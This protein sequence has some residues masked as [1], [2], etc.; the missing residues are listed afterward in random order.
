MGLRRRA[1]AHYTRFWYRWIVPFL[2]DMSP[3]S[4]TRPTHISGTRSCFQKR[5]CKIFLCF[6]LHFWQPKGSEV[7][8]L[9]VSRA[10]YSVLKMARSSNHEEARHSRPCPRL[11][12]IP[13]IRTFGLMAPTLQDQSLY[14]EGYRYQASPDHTLQYEC[15]I[16]YGSHKPHA[17]FIKVSRTSKCSQDKVPNRLYATRTAPGHGLLVFQITPLTNGPAPDPNA[18]WRVASKLILGT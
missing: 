13:H 8:K 15:R 4:T 9:E 1:G 3:I 5:A 18:L 11:K 16:Q 17:E 12:A 14:P 7:R 2:P 6:R 10:Q